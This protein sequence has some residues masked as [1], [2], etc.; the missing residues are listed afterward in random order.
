MPFVGF[1]ESSVR[2]LSE[3]SRNDDLAWFEARRDECERVLIEPAKAFVLALGERLR[4]LDPKIQAIPRV[5]GSIHGM[6]RRRRF[7]RH[8]SKPF[9]DSLDVWFW[10]GQ[11]RAWENSGFFVRLRATELVLAC[12]II[13]F[14]KQTLARYREHVLDETRG[15]ALE[16]IVSELGAKGY[17]VGGESYKRTPPGVSMDHPRAALLRHRGLFATLKG[18]HPEQLGTPAFVDFAFDH[19]QSMAKLHHWLVALPR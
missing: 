15:T 13:E 9:R 18:D 3:L 4:R 5:R 6:E 2:F 11:R 1:P 19:F 8:R 10:S 12:G 14:Q 7:P 16:L 17:F